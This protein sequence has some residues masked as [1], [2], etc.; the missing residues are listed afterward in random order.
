MAN[1]RFCSQCGESLEGRFKFCPGC[2]CPAEDSGTPAQPARPAAGKDKV[3]PISPE[4]R[5]LLEQFDTQFQALKDKRA[6]RKSSFTYSFRNAL[7]PKLRVILAASSVVF[8]GIFI[9]LMLW[10]FHSMAGFF[11][12]LNVN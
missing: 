6:V 12:A 8:G 3:T 10:I 4:A 7:S 5:K 9:F 2:G 11:K 1:A